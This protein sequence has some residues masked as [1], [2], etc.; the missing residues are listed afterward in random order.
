M[1]I[2]GQEIPG[3]TGKRS[4]LRDRCLRYGGDGL[5]AV[6]WGRREQSAE[7]VEAGARAGAQ[8][9]SGIDDHSRYVV[10]AAVLAVPSDRAVADAFV[11]AMKAYG[12]S[13]TGMATPASPVP[14]RTSPGRT[15]R[16]AGAWSPPPG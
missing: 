1:T 14:A 12:P 2:S 13:D 4:P 5:T 16:A 11:A 8:V 7:L 9:L 15:S 10:C 6:E 3:T